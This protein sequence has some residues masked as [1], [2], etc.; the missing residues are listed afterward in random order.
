M[1]QEIIEKGREVKRPNPTRNQA[2]MEHDKR[3]IYE[4]LNRTTASNDV[5]VDDM[6]ALRQYTVDVQSAQQSARNQR[7]EVTTPLL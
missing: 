7:T 6:K 4:I 5:T 2:Q 3:K 1:W